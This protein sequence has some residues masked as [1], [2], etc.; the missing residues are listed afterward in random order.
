MRKGYK[1]ILGIIVGLLLISLGVNFYTLYFKDKSCKCVRNDC[2]KQECNCKESNNEEYILE[3]F[4]KSKDVRWFGGNGKLELVKNKKDGVK[5]KTK[6]DLKKFNEDYIIKYLLSN[7]SSDSLNSWPKKEINVALAISYI[8][9]DF[10]S[11]FDSNKI[12]KKQL[13]EEAMKELFNIEFNLDDYS[14]FNGHVYYIDDYYYFASSIGATEGYCL[15]YD[16][17]KENK[18]AIEYI[19]KACNTSDSELEYFAPGSNVHITYEKNNNN[20]FIKSIVENIY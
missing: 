19:Y 1:I 6:D 5:L 14:I 12:Y 13:V 3:L 11:Y 20:Y 2:D 16:S 17:I 8:N 18:N 7:R 4:S 15:E 10:Y 9:S